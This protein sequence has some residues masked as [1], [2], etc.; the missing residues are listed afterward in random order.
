MLKKSTSVIQYSVEDIQ[1]LIEADLKKKKALGDNETIT[2]I[3]DVQVA[4]GSIPRGQFDED[5]IYKFGGVK[6]YI[7]SEEF[8]PE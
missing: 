4:N 8:I 7:E 3:E 6:L 5:L 2:R 1:K